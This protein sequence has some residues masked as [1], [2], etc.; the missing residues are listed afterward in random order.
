ML[1]R[2]ISILISDHILINPLS[3]LLV[4]PLRPRE[5]MKNNEEEHEVAHADHQ[6]EFHQSAN[7][8]TDM[9]IEIR[10]EVPRSSIVCLGCLAVNDSMEGM[11]HLL[12][13]LSSEE[14][15][16]F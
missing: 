9:F 4:R 8:I 2:T 7:G 14:L 11:G 10:A 12:A 3:W 1:A 15:V 16:H 13:R 6:Q 5:H